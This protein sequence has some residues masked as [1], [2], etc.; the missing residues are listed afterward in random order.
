VSNALKDD[1]KVEHLQLFNLLREEDEECRA[2]WWRGSTS[3]SSYVRCYLPALYL[4]GQSHG[5]NTVDLVE[6]EDGEVHLIR[7]RGDVAIWQ[8]PGNRPRAEIMAYQ[9]MLGT[10]TIVEVDDNYL[11]PYP[12]SADSWHPTI[13]GA[14]GKPSMEEHRLIVERCTDAVICATP[15]LAKQYE[16]VHRE[17]YVAPNCVE[18]AHWPSL[19]VKPADGIF[20]IAYA[21]SGSHH[22]DLP[23]VMK[24][25]EW[26]S[27]QDGVEVYFMGVHPKRDPGFP[28]FV[29][30]WTD[31]REKYCLA[32]TL[33]D[34]GLAP[35]APNQWAL[36]KSD[37]KALEY[38]M[39]G[40]LPVVSAVEPY[41]PWFD[42]P[43]LRCH[44]ANGFLEAI[45]WCVRNRD[46]VAL[47][48]EQARDYVLAERQIKDNVWRWEEA[49]AGKDNA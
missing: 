31:T 17:V 29:I 30:P 16:R 18:P 3:G 26:A 42:G 7:Q 28:H 39:A 19:S 40:A 33:F 32:L 10:R 47:I 1:S 23:L 37:L 22:I 15:F 9:Q 25:L 13:R 44:N 11:I 45:Q 49:I 14:Q 2:T 43:A 46:D 24:A 21:G 36:G 35:I 27:R 6:G 20:R 34:V 12:H 5:L 48:A 4:P 41:R 38:A 8:F